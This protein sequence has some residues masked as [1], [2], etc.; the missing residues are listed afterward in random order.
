VLTVVVSIRAYPVQRNILMRMTSVAESERLALSFFESCDWAA[1]SL[2][3][4]WKSLRAQRLAIN[5]T[6]GL[7]IY[8]EL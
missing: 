2:V 8:G 6:Q 4:N 3:D 7:C 1:G 5:V